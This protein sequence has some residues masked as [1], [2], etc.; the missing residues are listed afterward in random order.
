MPIYQLVNGIS[1]SFTNIQP[2]KN[3]KSR[4]KTSRFIAN[5][6]S[7]VFY[8]VNIWRYN[9]NNYNRRDKNNKWTQYCAFNHVI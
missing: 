2:K 6:S 8:S 4:W 5:S 7:S 1:E 3:K 9:D